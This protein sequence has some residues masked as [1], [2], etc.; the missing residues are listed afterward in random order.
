ME[1]A[2]KVN[3]IQPALSLLGPVGR[4]VDPK[5]VELGLAAGHV[6]WIDP[7]AAANKLRAACEVLLDLLQVPATK[8]NGKPEFLNERINYAA[9]NNLIES[10]V[11][12]LLHGLRWLGNSGSH[13]APTV[14]ASDAIEGGR[15][16]ALA[17]RLLFPDPEDDTARA[18]ALSW[19]QSKGV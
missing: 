14:K 16:L 9:T 4:H 13:G 17:L 7:D 3:L 11:R 2:L 12:E 1:V 6:V 8:T 15:V 18:K 10:D 19:I 5:I